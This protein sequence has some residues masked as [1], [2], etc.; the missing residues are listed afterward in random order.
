MARANYQLLTVVYSY[1]SNLSA[2]TIYFKAVMFIFIFIITFNV[3]DH[4]GNKFMI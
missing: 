3:M 1:H 4:L 2:L